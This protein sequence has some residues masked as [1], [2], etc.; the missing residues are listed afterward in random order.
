[1]QGS[2]SSTCSADE[3]MASW[4]FERGLLMVQQEN[5][6]DGRVYDS[7]L[8]QIKCFFSNIYTWLEHTRQVCGSS[9]F[10][11]GAGV[12]TWRRFDDIALWLVGGQS[13]HRG[14]QV[15]GQACQGVTLQGVVLLYRTQTKWR[16]RLLSAGQQGEH[17]QG[18]IV[19]PWRSMVNP[20]GG[21]CKS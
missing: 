5:T 18:C 19:K 8:L 4:V 7:I 3:E 12:S 6:W 1:M 13:L 16:E 2:S 14:A 20:L 10:V 15:G 17:G 9:G 21:D 11:L